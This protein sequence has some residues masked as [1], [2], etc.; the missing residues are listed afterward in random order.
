MIRLDNINLVFPGFAI[1]NINL[2]IREKD[3]FALIG[4][5]GSGKSV[6]LE[7]IMGLT[8][9]PSGKL[10]F[11]EK[12]IGRTPVEKR[13]LALVYQDFALFPHLSVAHNILYGIRYHGIEIDESH[14]R[15]DELANILG[16]ERILNRKPHKL[17]GGEKQRVALARALILN[18]VVLLLDEPLSALDPEFHGE[19]KNLLKQIHRDMD[20]TIVM[21][22]HNF[23]DV[24][25]LANRGAVIHQGKI[26]QAGDITTL[27]EKPDSLFTARFVGMKNIIPARIIQG[28]VQIEGSDTLIETS[29]V[30]DFD[31]GFMGIR[32]EDIVL[33]S[34][35][36]DVPATSTNQFCGTITKVASQ[37]M[38][39]E[40][41]LESGSLRFEAAW[42]RRYLRDFQIAPDREATIAFSPQSVHVF[43]NNPN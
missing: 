30:P 34:Q 37:G 41:H 15:L 35:G 16:L 1:E 13:H 39:V 8:P 43:Q 33:V 38:F 12:N 7:I 26:C 9:F 29:V 20:M 32:P 6:L 14:K 10:L 24:M 3:F 23:G 22:S 31:H 2:T 40:V 11:K 19:A 4:P 28:K 17:S 36:T 5:T 18:P 21:V 42:P 27:F 25:Y